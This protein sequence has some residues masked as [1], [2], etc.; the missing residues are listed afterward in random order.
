MWNWL[1]LQQFVPL[2][3]II[4]IFSKRIL[5]GGP[6]LVIGFHSTLF[7][8][9][10]QNLRLLGF[11]D[12]CFPPPIRLSAPQG[13]TP[14]DCLAPCTPSVVYDTWQ[15]F[16]K[17]V[18]SIKGFLYFLVSF[19]WWLALFFYFLFCYCSAQNTT[20]DGIPSPMWQLQERDIFFPP[21]CPTHTKRGHLFKSIQASVM[22]PEIQKHSS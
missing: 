6:P 20:A 11:G 16:F 15:F 1:Y 17:W 10:S 13:Q 22:G 18:W 2:F 19:W 21:L 12:E 5:Q 3:Q 7:S 8:F 4:I 14:C 9:P